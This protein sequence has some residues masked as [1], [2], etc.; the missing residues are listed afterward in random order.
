[1]KFGLLAVRP[2]K[3]EDTVPGPKPRAPASGCNFPNPTTATAIG[4]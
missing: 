2:P 3:W 4:S 1:M